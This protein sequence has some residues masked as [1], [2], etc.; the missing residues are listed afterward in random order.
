MEIDKSIG[1][2]LAGLGLCGGA[3]LLAPAAPAVGAVTLAAVAGAALAPSIAAELYARFA[4]WTKGKL[5][6]KGAA[7][8]NHDLREMV[9]MSIENVLEDVIKIKPG[10][11][12][13]VR[14]L[15]TYKAK[16]R[17]RQRTAAIDDRFKG[18]WEQTVPHYFKARLEEFSS[19]KA[20]T[21]DIWKHFLNEVSYDALKPGEQTALDAAVKAL[22]NELPKHLVGVYRDALQHHPTIFVAVQTAILQEIWNGVSR[23]DHKVDALRTKQESVLAGLEEVKAAIRSAFPAGFQDA[24]VELRVLGWTVEWLA[25][26]TREMV[27]VVLAKVEV[28]ATEVAIIRP[29]QEGMAAALA[30]TAADMAQMKATMNRAMALLEQRESIIKTPQPA[31]QAPP[32]SQADR[33][34]LD[35]AKPSAEALTRYRIAVAE[36]STA[37]AKALQ[38]EVERLLSTRR[39]DE[40]FLFARAKGDLYWGEEEYDTASTHYR[41]ALALQPSDAGVMNSLA[42]S[43]LRARQTFDYGTGLLEAERLL[44]AAVRACADQCRG[45]TQQAA[46]ILHNLAGVSR[47][48][49]RAS[50][51][52]SMLRVSLAMRRRSHESDHQDVARSLNNLS[53]VLRI[54]GRAS[55]A[56]SYAHDAL[57]MYQ[58]I[59]KDDHPD[60]AIALNNVALVLQDLER[61]TEAEPLFQSAL[62]MRRRIYK[63]DHPDVARS[64]DNLACVWRIIGR[65]SE[66]EPLA[67]EALAM[68]H[69]LYKSNHP[70]IAISMHNIAIVLCDLGRASEAEPMFR[71]AIEMRR[72][73]YKGDHPDLAVNLSD[74]AGFLVAQGRMEPATPLLGEAAAMIV[75]VWGSEH[76]LARNILKQKEV[77]CGQ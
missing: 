13:G 57:V 8:K 76:P 31:D 53:Y 48:L 14:L 4:D 62:A 26:E 11:A 6:D 18:T 20:L 41:A 70:E 72:R 25:H 24:L 59:N 50:E 1:V 15:K 7:G 60:V 36:G 33:A 17:E 19:V 58:R 44:A 3:C 63:S 65:T 23:V 64:L 66:A 37:D 39:A 10:G 74:L 43:L 16:V 55:E 61:A 5:R 9:V 47:L 56:E 75:R 27:G 69:R 54:L 35:A 68:K 51:A 29:T 34:T 67:I 32:L 42:V 2:L 45:D 52:E 77:V 49:G 71:D 30:S 40:D 46:T 73:V 12:D 22:Y 21:P 38:P 28:L